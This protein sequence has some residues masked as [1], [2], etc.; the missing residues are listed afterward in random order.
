VGRRYNRAKK[1]GAR[2]DLTSRH[3]D[4]KSH[5]TAEKIA[6]EHGVGTRTVERAGQFADAIEKVKAIAPS[7]EREVA[8]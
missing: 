1:Q 3:I 6:R 4:G 2:T 5:Q 7:I 8:E